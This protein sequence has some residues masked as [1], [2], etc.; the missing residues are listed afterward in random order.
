M[1]EFGTTL[2][3]SLALFGCFRSNVLVF[4]CLNVVQPANCT[5]TIYIVFV[6]ILQR[7]IDKVTSRL[8]N[9]AVDKKMSIECA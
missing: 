5:K 8:D 7:C 4:T 3:D 1:V 6:I 2:K 9:V